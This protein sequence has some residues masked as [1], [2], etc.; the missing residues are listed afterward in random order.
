MKRIFIFLFVSLCVI[1]CSSESE[2]TPPVEAKGKQVF[3]I[4]LNEVSA[5]TAQEI[6]QKDLEPAF[7]IVSINNSSG[8][9]ILIREKIAL[10]KEGDSYITS[11]ISLTEGIY[12]LIEFIVTDENDMV[13]SLAPR[14]SSV[15]AEFANNPLPFDFAVTQDKTSETTT[16]NIEAAGYSSIN[17]GYTGL[18][19]IFPLNNDF[20]NLT[21][22]DSEYTTTKI[23]NLKSISGSTYQIDWGDGTVD[24]YVSTTVNSG[25][26]NSISHEY[27]QNGEY[28][29][30][31]SGA[32]EAIELIDFGGSQD[33]DYESHLTAIDLEKL[34]LLK[35]CQLY[36]GKLTGLN[37]SGNQALEFLGLGYNQVTSLDFTNNPNLKT[38]WLR[39]NQLTG[40]DVSQ[41]P[42]L[43]FLWVDGNQISALDVSGNS[44]LKVILAR[45]NNLG[46]IDLSNN[47]ELERLDVADNTIGTIDV[48]SNLELFEIN[49]GGNGLSSI[50]LSNNINLIRIDLYTNQL[51]T[52]DLSN[53]LRLKDLYINGNGLTEINVS[54]NEELERLIIAD[55]TMSTLDIS[56]NPLIFDLEVENNQLSGAELDQLIS[57]V[58]DQTVLNSVMNGYVSYANNPGSD[59]LDNTTLEKINE[60]VL[61]YNWVFWNP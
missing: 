55:N 40:L 9:P 61:D 39:Y 4:N 29:I 10:V 13:I 60:L 1:S 42:N 48:S 57:H 41:N 5:K 22:D 12:S 56:S 35:S 32:I 44:T 46:S 2:D 47:L 23:L 45:E 11:D 58:Y 27:A 52:I 14:E 38:V 18:G 50:D 53:N 8:T 37:T 21:V 51:S 25:L 59:G 7:A 19:L 20:F 16:E 43:E 54:A 6:G 49:V 17:F 15:M 24:E 26:E 3:R 36:Q 34:T 30:T 28:T 33:D 31:I